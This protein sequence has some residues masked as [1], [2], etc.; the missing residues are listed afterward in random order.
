MRL[1][2]IH[3]TM[4]ELW[5]EI[6]IFLSFFSNRI[7]TDIAASLIFCIHIWSIWSEKKILRSADRFED[8]W[9]SKHFWSEIHSKS[10]ELSMGESERGWNFVFLMFNSNVSGLCGWCLYYELCKRKKKKSSG[11][12]WIEFDSWKNV[13]VHERRF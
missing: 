4:N 12:D 5:F 7:H 1:I 2:G 9:S 3:H 6:H 10:D 11:D 13:F 8:V